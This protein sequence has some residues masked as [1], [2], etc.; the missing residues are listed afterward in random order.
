MDKNRGREKEMRERVV[1]GEMG[2]SRAKGTE[3]EERSTREKG[4]G[5]KT[6][7]EGGIKKEIED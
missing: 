3:E 2:R 5:R 6:R 4:K 7:R 1:K